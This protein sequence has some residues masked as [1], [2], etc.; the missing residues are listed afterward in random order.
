[1][2]QR[3]DYFAKQ[4]GS[5]WSQNAFVDVGIK[6]LI[7][8]L[9]NIYPSYYFDTVQ[10][11]YRFRQYVPVSTDSIVPIP[12]DVVIPSTTTV[13]QDGATTVWQDTKLYNWLSRLW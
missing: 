12:T 7:N 6:Q 11:Y 9:Y 10:R 8:I 2:A 4:M 13:L 1:M 5:W 3:M